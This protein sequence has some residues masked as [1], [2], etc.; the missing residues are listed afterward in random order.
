VAG[1][2]AFYL[3]AQGADGE[4]ARELTEPMMDELRPL[5]A[6]ALAVFA[7]WRGAK[8]RRERWVRTAGRPPERR[9]SFM[10]ALG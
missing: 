4:R 7:V 9:V 6:P 5:L 8:Q 2:V 10:P 1:A 3:S